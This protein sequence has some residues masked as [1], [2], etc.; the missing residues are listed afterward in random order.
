LFGD[1][2]GRPLRGNDKGN[3]EGMVRYIRRNFMVPAPRYDSFDNLTHIS[4]KGA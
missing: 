1:K 2:F 3:F 4:K